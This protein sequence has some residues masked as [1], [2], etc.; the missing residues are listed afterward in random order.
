[1][2]ICTCNHLHVSKMTNKLVIYTML[3]LHLL[4]TVMYAG[5]FCAKFRH[6]IEICIT[7][8]FLFTNSFHVPNF[9]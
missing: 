6:L 9:T 3:N 7:T 8:G 1:M 2:Q 5:V 4:F